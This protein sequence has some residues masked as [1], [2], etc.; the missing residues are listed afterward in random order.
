MIFRKSASAKLKKSYK[1]KLDSNQTVDFNE[2]NVHIAA[3]LLKE[4]IRD[5]PDGVI[6][7]H[8]YSDCLNILKLNENQQK[9]KTTKLLLSRLPK[10]NLACLKHFMCVF[11]NITANSSVN[12]M[13]AH[14]ISVCVAP[15]IFHK[16]DR[17]S[18]VE[19]SFQSIA[20]VKFLIENTESLFGEETLDLFKKPSFDDQALASAEQVVA[21]TEVAKTKQLKSSK[22]QPVEYETANKNKSINKVLNLVTLKSKKSLAPKLKTKTSSLASY[23]NELT[24]GT[25]IKKSSAEASSYVPSYNKNT[26]EA[27]TTPNLTDHKKSEIESTLSS[28]KQAEAANF[29]F[30]DDDVDYDEYNYNEEFVASAKYQKNTSN[31][32][33]KHLGGKLGVNQMAESSGKSKHDLSSNTLSVD[34]GLSVPTA[35]NSDPESEKSLNALKQKPTNES[36]ANFSD[37]ELYFGEPNSQPNEKM[38]LM[39]QQQQAHFLKR[40]KRMFILNS[41]LNE[42]INNVV[43]SSDQDQKTQSL[44]SSNFGLSNDELD[45]SL[46]QAKLNE[47]LIASSSLDSV[48]VENA[49]PNNSS[50][51]NAKLDSTNTSLENSTKKLDLLNQAAPVV[52]RSMSKTVAPLAP[53]LR[54]SDESNKRDSLD[55]D[56]HLNDNIIANSVNLLPYETNILPLTYQ[57]TKKSEILLNEQTKFSS[58]QYEPGYSS[59]KP[60]KTSAIS[61]STTSYASVKSNYA[62]EQGSAR[63]KVDLNTVVA[64]ATISASALNEYQKHVMAANEKEK[65]SKASASTETN[66]YKS[67]KGS[68]ASKNYQCNHS[69]Q[70]P[71]ASRKSIVKLNIEKTFNSLIQNPF[72]RN[73][74]SGI[75]LATD[76]IAFDA[77]MSDTKIACDDCASNSENGAKIGDKSP[78][79]KIASTVYVPYSPIK[80][81][82]VNAR[83]DTNDSSLH[84]SSKTED[85]Q[86]ETQK[87][88]A[89]RRR[90]SKTQRD[91]RSKT[92]KSNRAKSPTSSSDLNVSSDLDESRS[93]RSSVSLLSLKTN[94]SRFS[95]L[96]LD[97]A[98]NRNTKVKDLTS[99]NESIEEKVSKKIEITRTKSLNQP[100]YK[101]NGPRGKLEKKFSAIERTTSN[102]NRSEILQSNS[103]LTNSA[104]GG[105]K[106]DSNVTICRTSEV[107]SSSKKLVI[108][109]S[110]SLKSEQDRSSSLKQQQQ[111]Q[112]ATAEEKDSNVY[113]IKE[114]DEE[115]GAELKEIIK[116]VKSPRGELTNTHR[117][118]SKIYSKAN[119]YDNRSPKKTPQTESLNKSFEQQQQPIVLSLKSNSNNINNGGYAEPIYSLSMPA[120]NQ[121]VKLDASKQ[122]N[123]KGSLGSNSTSS[124]SSISSSGSVLPNFSSHRMSLDPYTLNMLKTMDKNNNNNQNM[125]KNEMI[126]LA[127]QAYQNSTSSHLINDLDLV[128]V[129]W[130]V[131]NIRKQFEKSIKKN[132]QTDQHHHRASNRNS[133]IMPSNSASISASSSNKSIHSNDNQSMPTSSSSSSSYNSNFYHFY[134]DINGNPTTYI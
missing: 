118:I 132:E 49:N 128:G 39:Q 8:L 54:K 5:Y 106:I 59:N 53:H 100:K 48:L 71:H 29:E 123:S 66:E 52:R 102:A 65:A 105:S 23:Q 107:G 34:S 36:N 112:Q 40:Q 32:K 82:K 75:G 108:K 24:T 94:S 25:Y 93:R 113:K 97:R 30:C 117:Y 103:T 22:S 61:T 90:L 18:D 1:D 130:S 101:E 116:I 31:Q 84:S 110:I 51:S 81:L 10:W 44:S 45:L 37:H 91:Y 3:L 124:S 63:V 38:S 73:I 12:K 43:Y 104:Y 17:P 11:N 125:N 77:T 111:Q 121:T 89:Q 96:S 86:H 131:P 85:E 68:G 28:K 21:Q 57:K 27:K 60:S 35:T 133:A 87:A 79:A 2:M 88:S 4:Y 115:I 19:S 56:I 74:H 134:K 69:H 80:L 47:K 20:F 26:S 15:S 122:N 95:S 126:K 16:L 58:L 98:R 33:I 41:N 46:K 7:Y 42:L 127:N 83:V 76:L 9:L 109:R 6:D 114:K 78:S 129:T 14:N 13:D 50:S 92:S 99:S 70:H 119:L 67:L 64:S 72:I 55:A 120:A 62:G